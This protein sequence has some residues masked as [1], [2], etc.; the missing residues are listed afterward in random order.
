M[1][2][3][4][5]IRSGYAVTAC[6]LLLL[7][8]CATAPGRGISVEIARQ[9][10]QAQYPDLLRTFDL[11]QGIFSVNEAAWDTLTRAHRTEFLDRCLQSRRAITGQTAVRVDTDGDLVALYDSATSVFYGNPMTAATDQAGDAAGGGDPAAVGSE[12]FLVLLSVPRPVYPAA[13][14][15]AGIEGTVCLQARIGPD[16]R[17]KEILPLGGGIPLLN[18]AALEAA[19]QASFRPFS[20][21]E[22]SESVWVR[23]P[24]K[25]TLPRIHR[26]LGPRIQ[27]SAGGMADAVTPM[28]PDR[29]VSVGTGK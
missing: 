7:S 11:H 23:I 16:G 18:G 14:L 2:R 9:A 24:M 8:S 6:L 29:S 22:E 21:G 12:P 5:R 15:K 1:N 19:R 13:A 4:V 17:V 10:L 28:E 27:S 26:S 3:N 20:G 25:F